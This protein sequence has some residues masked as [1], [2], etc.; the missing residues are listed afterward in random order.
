M[1]LRGLKRHRILAG[2]TQAE[3]ADQAGVTRDTLVRLERGKQPP[4]PRTLK[5]LA[6]V[7]EV[8]P[9]ELVSED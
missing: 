3:L 1:M 5:K 2:L 8:D 6:E 4:R 9:T 7:L